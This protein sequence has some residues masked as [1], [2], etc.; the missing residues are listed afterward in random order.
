MTD[1]TP[2]RPLSI[3]AWAEEEQ[4]RE[5][6]M[7][8]GKAALTDAEL[9]A[10]LIGSGSVDEN[11]IELS[12]RLLLSVNND[13]SE[14]GR[15]SIKD[16]TKFKGIGE[17]KAI[18]I[19]AA[20]ELG[21]RRQFSDI[22]Q[23]NSISCSRDIY[24]VM[25]PLLIDLKYEEFWILLLNRANHIVGKVLVSKGGVSG[26][27]VDSKLVFKPALEMLATGI[28]LVHNHPSGN[29]KPSSADIDLTQK[30]FKGG[31]LLDITVHDHVII[32]NSGYYS[33]ADMDMMH[34]R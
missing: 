28:I 1:Y 4:P 18:T 6:M 7:L 3:K 21:R 13:L 2:Q 19:I 26:T 20:L 27:V 32:S 15:S 30:L 25:L 24:D 22:L 10:I 5:K 23:R 16:L 8:K 34:Y 9:I 12:K 33:F 17:A 31:K 14:L 29:L 11:A